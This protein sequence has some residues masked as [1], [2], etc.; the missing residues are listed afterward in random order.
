MIGSADR[1]VGKTLL[2]CELIRRH[3]PT[4]A[5]IAVKITTIKK[6]NG[7][8]PRGGD[9][10]GVCGNLPGKFSLTE[11]QDRPTNKDTTRLLAAGASKVFWL[12]VHAA[13]L[14]EGVEALLAQIP[15]G[16]PSIWESNSAR[17]AVNPGTFLI[18]REKG[19]NKIKESCLRVLNQADR[20]LDFNGT[21]WD[22]SPARISFS[23]GQ[24]W[25]RQD[26]TA[27]VL[28]GG[29]SSR[30][31]Q[32]KNF[33]PVH[34]RPMIE[35]I[36]SQL[37]PWF[38]DVLIGANEPA[39]FSF[40]Q[41]RVIPDREPYMG[42]L[43]G[44]SSCLS[45]SS[46][47]LNFVTACDI[48]RLDPNFIMQ[49]IQAAGGYDIVMPLSPDRRPEPLLAVYRKSVGAFADQILARGG[50][51]LTSLFDLVKVKFIDM[52]DADWYRNVNTP[53]DYHDYV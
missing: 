28:A 40:L 6:E 41:R 44:L 17:L 5:I 15:A 13:H 36:I 42:P 45:K 21:S 22:L 51:R 26:A 10:C 50:R 43:M 23:A 35:H 16:Q 34:G 39:K 18:L 37:A 14:A 29:K 20:V 48:P 12:R 27:I 24:W 53:E 7:T 33:L 47:E 31:G 38:D 25:V 2:A 32:D 3:A 4:Q 11:I 19:S 8:C 30:M 9:G 1:N 49:M 52:P 46:T